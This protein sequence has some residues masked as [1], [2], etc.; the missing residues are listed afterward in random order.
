[1]RARYTDK[2]SSASSF[3]EKRTILSLRRVSP[4][5]KSKAHRYGKN[6]AGFVNLRSF[7]STGW[8]ACSFVVFP[9]NNA[10]IRRRSRYPKAATTEVMLCRASKPVPGST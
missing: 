7:D 8:A 5:R 10:L 6:Y 4:A 2:A 3:P 1:M 9:L